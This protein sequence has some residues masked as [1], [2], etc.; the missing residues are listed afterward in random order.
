MAISNKKISAFL[1]NKE[2]MDQMIFHI[3]NSIRKLKKENCDAIIWKRWQHGPHIE[4]V[5]SGSKKDTDDTINA[6]HNAIDEFFKNV[7][8][9]QT[10]S[11]EY[12]NE[13][14]KRVAILENYQGSIFPLRKHLEIV[15]DTLNFNDIDTIFPIDTYINIEKLASHFICEAFPYYYNADENEKNVFLSE[16]MII[17]GNQQEKTESFNGGIKYG[18]MTFQSHFQGFRSQIIGTKNEIVLIIQ[19][20]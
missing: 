5:I 18:Y 8:I 12:Y 9:P 19:V 20:T 13:L 6:L 2:K 1:Y 17:L 3:I 15:V 16:C 14:S 10:E 7:D 4:V 11:Y